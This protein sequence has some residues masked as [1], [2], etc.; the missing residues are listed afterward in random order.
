G[1][2]ESADRTN[3]LLLAGQFEPANFQESVIARV[4]AFTG[5]YERDFYIIPRLKTGL[6]AQLTV[7]ATPAP[8]KIQYGDRPIGAVLFLRLRN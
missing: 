6:G 4:Q 7:Y 8:L 3:E 5:G 1:R 2:I